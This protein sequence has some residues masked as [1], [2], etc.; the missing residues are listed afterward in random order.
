MQ[1]LGGSDICWSRLL[2][3]SL[4]SL[5][6]SFPLNSA[7]LAASVHIGAQHSV[8]ARLIAPALSAEPVDHGFFIW[9]SFATVAELNIDG[10]GHLEALEAN[11]SNALKLGVDPRAEQE[12]THETA[13]EEVGVEQLLLGGALV[14]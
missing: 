4:V 13:T 9:F 5:I 3:L 10:S 8:N 12:R 6:G 7:R 11:C 14:R 2:A 1:R